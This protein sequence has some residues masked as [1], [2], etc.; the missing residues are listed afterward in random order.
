MHSSHPDDEGSPGTSQEDPPQHPRPDLDAC[1]QPRWV[2]VL[3]Y[4]P[5]WPYYWLQSLPNLRP[6]GPVITLL[7]LPDLYV[8]P[9]PQV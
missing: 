5:T 8:P 2:L 1:L 6:V 4:L 9:F 3:V 7:P